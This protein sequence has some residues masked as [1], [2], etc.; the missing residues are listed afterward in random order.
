MCCDVHSIIFLYAA[1]VA[2]VASNCLTG[3]VALWEFG[4]TNNL[5]GRVLIG[6]RSASCVGMIVAA[7]GAG[8]VRSSHCGVGSF[9]DVWPKG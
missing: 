8:Y 1:V 6:A 9:C 7:G 3:I 5:G 4:E 2:T